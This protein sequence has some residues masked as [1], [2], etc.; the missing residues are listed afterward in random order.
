[1]GMT[2]TLPADPTLDEIREARAPLVAD[3][4]AFDGRMPHLAS[5]ST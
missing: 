2:T 1:M 3:N 5:V 4:A